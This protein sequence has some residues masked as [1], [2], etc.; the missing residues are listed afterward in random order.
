MRCNAL[1]TETVRENEQFRQLPGGHIVYAV[2]CVPKRMKLPQERAYEAVSG[3]GRVD[4][5]YLHGRGECFRGARERV[6]AVRAAGVDH[7][8]DI[9]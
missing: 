2:R 5:F 8:P 1:C 6:C 7:E 9:T 3:A 4:R